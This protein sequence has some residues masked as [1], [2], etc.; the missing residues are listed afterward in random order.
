MVVAESVHVQSPEWSRYS[1]DYCITP[2]AS[3][4]LPANENRDIK[5]ETLG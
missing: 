1:R 3:C 4:P 2:L 5:G